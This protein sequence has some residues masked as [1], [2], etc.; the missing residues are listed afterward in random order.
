[1]NQRTE[2]INALG[3]HLSEFGDVAP[4]GVG[5]IMRL[6]KVVDDPGSGLPDLARDICRM[7]LEQIDQ[8]LSRLTAFSAKLA[9]A[10]RATPMPFADH[11]GCRTDHRARGRNL[12][13][14]DEP[15]P[16]WPRFRRL[17]RVGAAATFVRRK[18]EAGENI[19]DGAAGHSPDA[20]H[21]RDGRNPLG[22]APWRTAKPLA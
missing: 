19:E 16:A 10:S 7:V 1:M 22:P 12:R 14:A 2:A 4:E 18:A 21:R 20:C 6:T 3:A 5:Y 17:A 13:A 9:A 11:A 8:L 15:V